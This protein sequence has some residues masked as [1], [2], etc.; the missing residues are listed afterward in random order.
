VNLDKKTQGP[1]KVKSQ[2]T[3][4]VWSKE[5][6][7][8]LLL[9]GPCAQFYFQVY[10]SETIGKADTEQFLKL[11]LWSGIV[12]YLVVVGVQVKYDVMVIDQL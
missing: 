5:S 7:S 11:N 6:V 1:L 4:D 12:Y 10:G 9:S 3:S 8:W 2:Y